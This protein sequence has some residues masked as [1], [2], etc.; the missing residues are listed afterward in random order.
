MLQKPLPLDEYLDQLS[1][2]YRKTY[3]ALTKGDKT[4]V[5]YVVS[6]L[7]ARKQIKESEVKTELEALISCTVFDAWH[8]QVT[9]KYAVQRRNI[10]KWFKDDSQP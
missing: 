8:E 1:P 9:G 3:K 4:T 10:E 6:L 5:Q 7:L 2:I